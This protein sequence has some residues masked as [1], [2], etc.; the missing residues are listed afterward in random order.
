MDFDENRPIVCDSGTGSVKAGFAG[1]DAPCVLF[2]SIIGRPRN[3]H[4]MIGI[5]Q[6]AET[7][8]WDGDCGWAWSSK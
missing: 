3:R 6:K 5:G 4:A 1:D 7:F 8:H 2:P